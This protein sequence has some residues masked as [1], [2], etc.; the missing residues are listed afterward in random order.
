MK[1]M[2]I[3]VPQE[4]QRGV[5]LHGMLVIVNQTIAGMLHAK[6]GMECD[7]NL[8]PV[9][10][11]WANLRVEQVLQDREDLLVQLHEHMKQLRTN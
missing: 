10:L 11:E 5:M 7:P 9:L 1:M 8:P 6:A 4:I 3:P 2:Q